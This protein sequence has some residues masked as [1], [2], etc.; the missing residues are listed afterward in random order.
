[1]TDEHDVQPDDVAPHAAAPAHRNNE[2]L[3]LVLIGVGVAVLLFAASALP[4]I[5]SRDDDTDTQTTTVTVESVT[6]ETSPLASGS[7]P[8]STAEATAATDA[9]DVSSASTTTI[10]ESPTASAPP[11]I[12]VADVPESVAVVLGGQIFLEGAVPDEASRDEIVGLATEIFG[13]DNVIDNY[14]IDED[15]SDPS[16]GNIRVDD[17]VLFAPDS[18]EISPEFEPLLNQGLALLTIRP[19]A[20]LVVEGH[21]DSLGGD[22]YNLELSQARA[23]SVVQWWV[24]RGVDPVRLTAIGRGE[25]EPIAS[26]DT[27]DGRERNRRIEVT[28]ENLLVD[29]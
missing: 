12:P 9:E 11:T 19:A 10:G 1:M 28:I 15:A 29:G 23:D 18:A 2:P 17:I 27:R 26:N 24:D 22:Q 3:V 7:T 21:T 25:A 4:V 8:T 5:L 20:T 6:D 16:L 13:S 14:I